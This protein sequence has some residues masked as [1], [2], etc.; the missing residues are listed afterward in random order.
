MRPGRESNSRILVL[1]RF[2]QKFEAG[3]G[4][5]PS[6]KSFADSRL[7][8]W[9]SGH[10][11]QTFVNKSRILDIVDL[12][13][14]KYRDKPM[15]YHLAT[16]PGACLLFNIKKL[17]V[18]S[19]GV[20]ASPVATGRSNPVGGGNISG[21]SRPRSSGASRRQVFIISW[22]IAEA[23]LISLRYLQPIRRI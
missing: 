17:S 2:L 6:Y 22:R 20:I 23:A 10:A 13:F 16:R 12:R 3:E 9:L 14:L 5:E 8:T 11:A 21:S 15:L 18:Q 1:S 4:I 19:L 7:T